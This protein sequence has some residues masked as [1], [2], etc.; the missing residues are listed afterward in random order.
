MEREGKVMGTGLNTYRVKVVCGDKMK[1]EKERILRVK[2]K[3]AVEQPK[4]AK[5]VGSIENK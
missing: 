5:Q 2:E 1:C 4:W 3:K